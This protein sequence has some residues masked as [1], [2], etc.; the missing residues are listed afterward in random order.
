MHSFDVEGKLIIAKSHYQEMQAEA[1][2]A[3]IVAQLQTAQPRS[4]SLWQ[5]LFGR[6][7]EP[8][9]ASAA[10]AKSVTPKSGAASRRKAPSLG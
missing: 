8:I 5:R 7:T 3:R 1:A 4:P 6:K 10:S 2:R 9:P